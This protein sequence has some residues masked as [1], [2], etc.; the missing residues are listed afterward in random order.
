MGTH[1]QL[2]NPSA[3]MIILLELYSYFALKGHKTI[4]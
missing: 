4:L 3:S 1:L 2:N